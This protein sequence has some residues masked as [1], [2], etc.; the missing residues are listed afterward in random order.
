MEVYAAPDQQLAWDCIVTCFFIDCANNIIAYLERIF[1][2]LKEGGT[3]LNLGPL[4]YHYSDLADE[5]S[6]E[7]SFDFLIDIIQK[8][9]F[10]VE[11]SA[12]IIFYHHKK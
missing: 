6:I 8:I 2:G 10:I 12:I 3:W 4:L 7:P 1:Y 9:G 11:V 5:D